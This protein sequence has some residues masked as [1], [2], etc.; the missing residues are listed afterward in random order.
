MRLILLTAAMA[1][2]ACSPSGA[3]ETGSTEAP[4]SPLVKQGKAIAEADCASCHAID[5]TSDSTHAEAPP[6][7]TLSQHYPIESLQEALA[8][9]IVVGH[10]DMPEFAFDPEEIDAMI[11]FLKSIQTK[12]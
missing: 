11:A 12:G 8:E 10:E 4:E 7:R 1:I 2:A 5:A 3:D 9:G 6:F